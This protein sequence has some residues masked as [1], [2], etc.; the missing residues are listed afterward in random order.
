[1]VHLRSTI[2]VIAQMQHLKARKGYVQLSK[3]NPGNSQAAMHCCAN[4]IQN[5]ED[6]VHLASRLWDGAVHLFRQV[7]LSIRTNLYM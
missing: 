1:M 4:S 3:P 7:D 5:P 2:L 6:A